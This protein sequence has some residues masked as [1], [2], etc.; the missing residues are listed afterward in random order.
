[1]A[2]EVDSEE[3]EEEEEPQSP[4]SPLW[5]EAE[6]KE[7]ESE[8]SSPSADLACTCSQS[9]S[10]AKVKAPPRASENSHFCFQAS[11]LPPS[12]QQTGERGIRLR[13]YSYSS[14]R[15]SFRPARP[16]RDS[17]PSDPSLGQ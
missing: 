12:P 3:E 13:S 6:K 8:G 7:D 14:P 2:L 16:T 11:T 10:S 4:L 15:I 5:S 9:A 17:N 1:M